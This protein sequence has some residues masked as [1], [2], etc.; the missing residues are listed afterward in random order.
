MNVKV[1]RYGVLYSSNF[2]IWI[3]CRAMILTLDLDPVTLLSISRGQ[4]VLEP[5]FLE[6]CFL[7]LLLVYSTIE[8][9]PGA[10]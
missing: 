6:V 4:N 3:G 5:R 8:R 7:R 1:R 2:G 9:F 10:I